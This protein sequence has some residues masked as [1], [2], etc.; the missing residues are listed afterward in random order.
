LWGNFKTTEEDINVTFGCATFFIPMKRDY[1]LFAS[2]N[3]ERIPIVSPDGNVNL[4]R[5]R[6]DF[7]GNNQARFQAI[8]QNFEY[9]PFQRIK[10]PQCR[11]KRKDKSKDSDPKRPR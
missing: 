2:T 11:P 8:S 4:F 1:L 5:D 9:F 6:F 3:I 10:K 7:L